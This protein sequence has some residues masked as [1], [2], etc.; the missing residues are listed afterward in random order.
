MDNDTCDNCGKNEEGIGWFARAFR[1]NEL[2]HGR[3]DPGN[4]CGSCAG[5]ISGPRIAQEVLAKERA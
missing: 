5:S 2:R 1:K 4:I 3:P